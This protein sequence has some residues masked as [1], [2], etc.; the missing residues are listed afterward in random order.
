MVPSIPVRLNHK[1]TLFSHHSDP[2]SFLR[3]FSLNPVGRLSDHLSFVTLE[4]IPNTQRRILY[5]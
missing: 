2:M 5:S 1:T 4:E 3:L